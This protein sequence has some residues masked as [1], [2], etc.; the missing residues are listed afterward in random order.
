MKYDIPMRRG[1]IPFFTGL[2]IVAT[3]IFSVDI[4]YAATYT[5][6]GDSKGYCNQSVTLGTGASVSDSITGTNCV[7]KFTGAGSYTWIRPAYISK[8]RVLVIGGGGGGGGDYG[9]GGGAGGFIDSTIAIS[10]STQNFSLYVAN[11]GAGH[12]GN[13]NATPAANGE[14]STAF[15]FSAIGGGGGGS[16]EANKPGYAG[17]SGGGAGSGTDGTTGANGTTG[18]GYGGGTSR[19][20]AGQTV[21]SGG[22][23]GAGQLG[24]NGAY[25]SSNAIGGSGGNGLQSDITGVSLYYSG[26]GGGGTHTGTGTCLTPA[27]S[28]GNVGNGAPG[29]LGGGGA[30]GQ[31]LLNS[32]SA[33]TGNAGADGSANTGGGGG[34]GSV[35]SGRTTNAHGG[36]GGS[37][38]VI[39]SY[40]YISS[41]AP[42]LT[43]PG[44]QSLIYRSAISLTAT[45]PVDGYVTFYSQ[46]KRIPGCSRI[47][48]TITGSNYQAVCNWRPSTHSASNISATIAPRDSFAPTVTGQSRFQP[49]PRAGTR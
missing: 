4:S 23:G 16:P 39:I 46:G 49:A 35:Q 30:A 36:N 22:G 41:A 18:Q 19:I 34:G 43:L 29:G 2:L 12:A 20:Y 38:I 14:T 45:S 37:G 11:G 3:S 21:Q 6:P 44:G 40:A 8:I 42:V 7:V 9:G 48:M 25:S 31:C 13:S 5:A 10:L 26:G 28:G 33:G 15:G 24:G 47:A 1:L 27:A 17:G 32:L